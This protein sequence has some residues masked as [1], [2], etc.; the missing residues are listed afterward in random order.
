MRL[1]DSFVVPAPPADVFA[2]LLDL[3]RVAPC[4]PGASVLGE[5][6][7]VHTVAIKVKVGPMSMQYRGTVEIVEQDPAAHR[8]VMRVRAKET[9]GGGTAEA[10]AE[11]RLAADGDGTS[12]AIGVDVSLS[13]KVAS[14]G[15]GAIQDVSS[16]IVATFAQNLA[17]M[18]EP[19]PDTAAEPTSEAAAG[20]AE[21]SSPRP[22]GVPPEAAALPAGDIVQ[23]V[24]A[25]RLREPKVAGGL[26]IVTLLVGYLLGRRSRRPVG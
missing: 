18:L 20:G 4:V 11:V 21:A 3:E 10:N 5:E 8:A 25:G 9:R 6:D 1:E 22:A 12:G 24:V 13:G 16:R 23:A 19:P 17:T 7:G 15:Q 2:T 14:M 26:A